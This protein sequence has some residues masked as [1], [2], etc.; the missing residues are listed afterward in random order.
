MSVSSVQ[1]THV[2]SICRDFVKD[3]S[4]KQECGQTKTGPMALPYV[5]NLA[6][7]LVPYQRRLSATSRQSKRFGRL[8]CTPIC[9]K[10]I[11]ESST[12]PLNSLESAL[13]Y[14]FHIA[15]REPSNPTYVLFLQDHFLESSLS[16]VTPK[17]QTRRKPFDGC[18]ASQLYENEQRR[19]CDHGRRNRND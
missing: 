16:D 2:D 17:Q 8:C 14:A 6:P 11:C 15:V 13:A 18:L 1:V 4:E 3:R 7:R 19:G 10:K 9:Q 5:C 12:S